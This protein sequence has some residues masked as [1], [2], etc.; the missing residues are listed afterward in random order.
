MMFLIFTLYG[1]GT[2]FLALTGETQLKNWI[3]RRKFG[4]DRQHIKLDSEELMNFP[5]YSND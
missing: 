3:L 4:P 2:W 1:C 5:S